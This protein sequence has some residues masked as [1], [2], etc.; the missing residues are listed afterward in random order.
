[1]LSAM[2]TASTTDTVSLQYTQVLQLM[3]DRR[4]SLDPTTL[5]EIARLLIPCSDAEKC[6]VHFLMENS[7]IGEDPF[8]KFHWLLTKAWLPGCMPTD[9][10]L[11]RRLQTL[12]AEERRKCQATTRLCSTGG[13]GRRQVAKGF[14][15]KCYDRANRG[16]RAR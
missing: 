5:A 16:K 7:F 8:L 9:C 13:C 2:A 15:R 4:S 3:S 10:R 6:A 14:C 12:A 1:M 11:W